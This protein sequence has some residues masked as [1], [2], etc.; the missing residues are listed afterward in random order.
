MKEQR[1]PFAP[2]KQRS[3]DDAIL[4]GQVSGPQD[5]ADM[6]ELLGQIEPQESGQAAPE[7]ELD[8]SGDETA[9]A[10]KAEEEVTPEQR[11]QQYIEGAEEIGEGERW[12]DKVFVF[13]KNGTV[14]AKE[15][16]RLS[17]FDILLPPGLIEVQGSLYLSSIKSVEGLVLPRKIGKTLDLG[18]I[19]SAKGLVLPEFIG[20][21]LYLSGIKL[22]EGLMLSKHVGQDL[23]LDGLTTLQGVTFPDAIGG[24]LFV[25]G[26]RDTSIPTG[27][28]LSNVIILANHQTTVGNDA[29][30]KGYQVS[31]TKEP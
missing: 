5:E 31:Y 30:K 27:I 7:A 13:N 17:R 29:E 26:L 6:R 28:N 19:T 18:G 12:V 11:R 15:D 2:D 25:R 10:R 4:V 23:F 20:M 24:N 1:Q 14:I 22:A 8:L 16:L 9:A 21:S 3:P